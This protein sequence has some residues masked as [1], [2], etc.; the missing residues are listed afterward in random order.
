M[1]ESDVTRHINIRVDFGRIYVYMRFKSIF[2]NILVYVVQWTMEATAKNW[3]V[4]NTFL[5]TSTQLGTV[6]AYVSGVQIG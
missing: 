5:E 3:P 2:E 1:N 4:S 6:T